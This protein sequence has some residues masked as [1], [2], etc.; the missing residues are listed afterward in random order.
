MTLDYQLDLLDEAARSIISLSERFQQVS[1]ERLARRWESSVGRT[2]E[3]IRSFPMLSPVSMIEPLS[4]LQLRRRT[5][6]DFKNYSLIYYIE[7]AHN[8]V[9]V[10]VLHG[11][12][13]PLSALGAIP[14]SRDEQ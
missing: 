1:S 2:L 14:L 9:I 7:D 13:D 5:I 4:G 3:S 10:V 6:S 8:I 11:A 12:R